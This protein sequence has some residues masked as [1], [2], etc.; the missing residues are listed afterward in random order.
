MNQPRLKILSISLPPRGLSREEAAAYA[1]CESLSTFS[2]WIRRGIMPDPIPG[3][4]KWDRKA[5]DAALDRP[6]RPSVY[7]HAFPVRPV[8][9][10]ARCGFTSKA[11]TRH[12]KNSL[13]ARPRNITTLG[14]MAHGSKLNPV[15]RNFTGSTMR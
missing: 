12:T 1:G 13:V 10:G 9:G 14:R 11:S 6:I 4:H 2:D 8:E 3:T 15:R 5:I 7:N